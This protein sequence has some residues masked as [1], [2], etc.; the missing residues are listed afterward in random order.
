[1]N[2]SPLTGVFGLSDVDG[3][4]TGNGPHERDELAG[5]GGDGDV[6]VLAAM[7][8]VSE[9]LA[10]T[11]LR[12]PADVLD[13]PGKLFESLADVRRDLGRVAVGP[14]S[15]YES[16]PGVGVA[17]F[18]DAALSAAASRGILA[19]DDAE[20]GGELAR[21]VEAGEIAELGGDGESGDLL[22]AS[23]SLQGLDDG[24]QA[25]GGKELVDVV[26][27]PLE[28]FDMIVDGSEVLLK[29]D[30][31]R[32]RGADNLGKI[33]AVGIVPVGAAGVVEA[34][35]KQEGLETMLGGLQI[36]ERIFTGAGEITDGLVIDL[37]DVDGSEVPGSQK[38]G[39]LESVATVGLDVIAGLARDER[40]SDDEAIDLLRGE[41]EDVAAGTGFVGN[42]E[43]GGLAREVAHELVDVGLTR[44]D[45]AHEDGFFGADLGGVGDRDR[46][47]VDIESDEEGGILGH[48]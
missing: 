18:G 26:F 16:A 36:D 12:L 21:R 20:E 14:G 37:R 22:N 15:L 48:G 30:L 42:E 31:L 24:A 23:Q 44:A 28:A 40:G 27:D 29:D 33:A 38:P 7:G 34:E 2:T 39:E 46:I 19:G 35:P 5:D 41:V 6:G 11:N 8:E 13:G 32:G 3:N 10:E 47:L 9:S 4:L 17:G 1:M 25:P 45:G 43:S